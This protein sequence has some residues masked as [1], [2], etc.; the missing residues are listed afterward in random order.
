MGGMRV[1]FNADTFDYEAEYAKI[2]ESVKRPNILLL[3]ATG[4]GKS[5]VVNRLFGRRVASVGAGVPVTR[6]VDRYESPELDVVLYDSEGY[7]IG[8]EGNAAF[9]E[10]VLGFIDRGIASGDPAERVHEAW[11][12]VSAANKRLTEM[13]VGTLREIASRRVPTAIIL[14][15]IDGVDEEEL[16]ALVAA[17]EF[18]CPGVPHF[19][20]STVEDGDAQ[21]VLTPYLQWE[22]LMDWASA[23]LDASLREGFVSSLAGALRQKREVAMG[24]VVPLYT[25]LAATAGAVPIPIADS[26]LLIPI[27]IKMSMHIMNTFG[28]ASD[29]ASVT[30]QFVGSEM[31]SQIGRSLAR[32][33]TAS[34]AKWVPLLGS[35]A[36][37]LVNATVAASFT[38]AMGGAVCELCYRYVQATVVEG[39]DVEVGDFFNPELIGELL[40][41]IGGGEKK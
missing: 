8:G 29:I 23:N 18:S 17:I 12:C 9:R 27:Q 37:G 24:R 7:E 6:G 19:N 15:Q 25:A 26:A 41:K 22:A 21:A 13:D 5:S 4:V 11:Y 34:L 39:R 38:G 10:N 33:M 31:I 36:G 1:N 14:T 16:A 28:M 20:T 3:G 30:Q 32:T 40:K 35:V 2:R